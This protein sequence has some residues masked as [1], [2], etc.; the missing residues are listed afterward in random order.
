MVQDSDEEESD[1]DSDDDNDSDASHASNARSDRLGNFI[2]AVRK[3]KL[4]T[5][6]NS[7]SKLTSGETKEINLKSRFYQKDDAYESNIKPFLSVSIR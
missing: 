1:S 4:I 5:N 6:L 3:V 2:S 7:N